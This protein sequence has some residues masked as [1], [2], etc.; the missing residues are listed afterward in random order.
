MFKTIWTRF[1]FG[2][3][4]GADFIANLQIGKISSN[5]Q[6]KHA[7]LSDPNLRVEEISC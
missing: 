1:Y 3:E 6:K 4:N 7:F 2:D 5:L